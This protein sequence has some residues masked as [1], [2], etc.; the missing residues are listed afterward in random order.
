MTRTGRAMADVLA[1]IKTLLDL[2]EYQVEIEKLKAE[3]AEYERKQEIHRHK[4]RLRTTG[5]PPEV[6]E[7][8]YATTFAATAVARFVNAPPALR[9]LVLAGRK[10]TGK[11]FAMARAVWEFGG[12]Y[13]DAQQLVASGTFEGSTWLDLGSCSLLAIDELGAEYPNPA[14]EANLYALLDRRYRQGR[15]TII[16]TNLNAPAFKARYCENG[17]DRLLERLK[18]GGRWLS[19]DG[20]SLR[21]SWQDTDDQETQP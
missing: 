7:G 2:P 3:D 9:F 20:P 12:R 6:T 21:K 1:S 10:G 4:N 5:V 18:T 13:V 19:L 16:A 15:R 11:T 17:L 8:E 14:F